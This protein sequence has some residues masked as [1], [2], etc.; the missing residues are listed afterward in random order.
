MSLPR[1]TVFSTG[2]TIASIPSG[3]AAAAPALTAAQ[4][5]AAV[6]QLSGVAEVTAVPF[7]QV[8]SSELTLTDMIALAREIEL[9]VADGVDGVVITQGTDTLEETSFALDLLWGGEAPVVLTGAMRNPALPGADGPAN[10]L[11]AVLLATSQVARGLGALVV[12]NDEVHLPLFVRK[13][14][15]ANLATFRSSLT[16]PI[17]W[18]TENRPSIAL[19]PA[20]RH[21][22]RPPADLQAIPPVAVLKVALGDDGRLLPAIASLGYRGLIVEAMGGGHVPRA[23]VEPLA[24]LARRIPVVLTSRT[25]AGEVL[26]GTYGFPGSETDLLGRGLI[27]AGILDGPKARLLLA[28]LLASDAPR[29]TIEAAFATIGAPGTGSAFRWPAP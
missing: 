21:A 16:G 9:A 24:D 8:P 2:G 23:M 27:H 1:V 7:R 3:D 12:F 13:T 26:R 28:L 10:L 19:R 22:I 25:G 6:P 11:G 18:I 4:L 20:V 29:E 15:T 5:V 14:H 17:G